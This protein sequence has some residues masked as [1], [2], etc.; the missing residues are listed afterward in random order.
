MK[1]K[2]T[3][4]IKRIP[5]FKLFSCSFLQK[6]KRLSYS[7]FFLCMI[8]LLVG[9]LKQSSVFPASNQN[10]SKP[11]IV[12]DA[13]HGGDDPGK[14]GIN[15]ELEKDLNLSIVLILKEILKE[16]YTVILTRDTDVMLCDEG[17]NNKK[18]SDL[19]N[20]VKLINESSCDIA[21]LIHQNSFQSENAKGAQVFYHAKSEDGKF[22]A[23]CLQEELIAGSDPSNTRSA[24]SDQTYYILKNA[25]PTVVIVEC[26]FLSN[27][28]EAARLCLLSYQESLALSIKNGIDRYFEEKE[29]N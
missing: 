22:L 12:L 24:K 9:I 4:F 5:F 7:F 17:V 13:G 11:V 26:G 3:E 23:T 18:T 10:K 6:K 19:K 15:G 29:S 27:P 14:V 28:E 25:T 2:L 1:H 21:I 16:D 8:L 20:R